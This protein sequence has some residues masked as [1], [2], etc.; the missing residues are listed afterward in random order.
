MAY[1]GYSI[2]TKLSGT[3]STISFPSLEKREDALW[4]C[5]HCDTL[6]VFKD[7]LCKWCGAPRKKEDY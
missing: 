1:S 4:H 5:N 3:F 6:N 2:D 7:T